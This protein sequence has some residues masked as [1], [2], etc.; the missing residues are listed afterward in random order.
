MFTNDAAARAAGNLN[1]IYTGEGL[2]NSAT[3][4]DPVMFE[5]LSD[6]THDGG[7]VLFGDGHV[8]FCGKA[9]YLQLI[10]KLNGTPRLDPEEANAVT[11][12]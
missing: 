11:R 9:Q 4:D 10:A 7:N 12:P 3:A 1:Y 8:E 2:T 6:H 5:M